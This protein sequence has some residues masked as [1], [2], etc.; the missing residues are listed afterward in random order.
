MKKL[1]ARTEEERKFNKAI[2]GA[3]AN[4]VDGKD[5][6]TNGHSLRVAQ[7]TKMLAQK[8]G[9]NTQTVD[10]FYNVALLHDI[11]KIGIPDAILQKPGKLTDEEFKI[12]KSHAERGYQILK[13]I[14]LQEDL[15]AG[16]H[17]HHERFD[18]KGY[19]DGLAGENI[20][21]VA[22]IIAV[23]DTFDAMSSTRPYRKKLPEDF[24]INEIK[25]CAGTQLDPMVV[26][27]FLELYKEGAFKDVF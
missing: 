24:I 18:G 11:G 4:C 9:E 16:A 26:E 1:K 14:Q 8:L 13:D 15:A 22:R 7:Y 19:P 17:H 2:I 21:W 10:K 5:T 25:N 6:Y 12:M 23:A 27:K 20:P 3:F